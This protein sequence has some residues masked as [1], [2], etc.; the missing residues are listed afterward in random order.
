MKRYPKPVVLVSKCLEFGKVRYNA[1]V[2]PSKIVRDLEPF[3]EYIKV[4]PEVE[5]GL[6][7][8]RDT[9]RIVKINGEKRL[10]QPK[11]GRDV[12]EEMREFTI[13]FLDDL[14]EVD[15]FIFK[16][17]SPTIGIR[18]IKVYSGIKDAVVVEKGSGFFAEQI[19]DKYSG[20]PMEEEDRLKNRRIR[21]HFL[22]HLFTFAAFREIKQKRSIEEL[23]EFYHRNRYLFMSY[24][25]ENRSH[26]DDL[27]SNRQE[28]SIDEIFV[29]Y[30]EFLKRLFSNPPTSDSILRTV[31]EIISRISDQVPGDEIVFFNE[32]IEKY[33]KNLIG[34]E[35]LM[36]ILK[37]YVIRFDES[38]IIDD[39]LFSPYP[40]ELQE[41]VDVDR[42]RNFWKN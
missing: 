21:N 39:A 15:G 7:V 34:Y 36:E 27:L 30:D 38:G 20:Y 28:R 31:K 19:M 41:V 17:R 1:Q 18:E 25:R 33:E 29:D 23:V 16:S 42:D 11:T 14:P 10:V 26:V 13:T 24:H 35:G 40:E 2:I 12:T 3:V 5:I 8:P 22:I 4:C 37:L 6:G 9:I 32:I